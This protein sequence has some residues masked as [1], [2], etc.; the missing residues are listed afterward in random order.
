MPDGATNR[1]VR[2]Y[3]AG[4]RAFCLCVEGAFVTDDA[5][6]V[7]KFFASFLIEPK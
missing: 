6:Y 4:D 7:E 2:V 5:R 1:I 3:R